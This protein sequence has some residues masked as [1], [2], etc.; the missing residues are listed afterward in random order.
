[1]AHTQELPRHFCSLLV[2]CP[3][4]VQGK[5]NC[6]HPPLLLSSSLTSVYLLCVG[7]LWR[8]TAC[9]SWFSTSALLVSGVKLRSSVFV[10]NVGS[11]CFY[12]L[13][14]LCSAIPI[15]WWLKRLCLSFRT[16]DSRT[17]TLTSLF[18][19]PQCLLP[20]HSPGGCWESLLSLK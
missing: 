15:S 1:M 10:I 7:L 8:M 6:L 3:P 5:R 19:Y 11:K 18:L 20:P 17:Q 12:S 9:G 16:I 14:H 13:S 4:Q 2:R